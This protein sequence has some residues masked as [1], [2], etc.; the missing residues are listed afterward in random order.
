VAAIPATAERFA[1]ISSGTWSLLGTMIASPVITDRSR[2][3]EFTNERG[4]GER[5]CS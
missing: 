4:V 3:L 5:P 2:E 1:F